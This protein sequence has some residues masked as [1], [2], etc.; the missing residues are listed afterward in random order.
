MKNLF[1][2]PISDSLSTSVD[3]GDEPPG[4]TLVQLNSQSFFRTK[5]KAGLFLFKISL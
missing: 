3:E 2:K 5:K 1:K 4:K